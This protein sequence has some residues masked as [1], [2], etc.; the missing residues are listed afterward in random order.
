MAKSKNIKNNKKILGNTKFDG[1][2]KQAIIMSVI[3]L[4]LFGAFYLLTVV[5]LDKDLLKDD[6][7]TVNTEI[8][9]SEILVGSSFNRPVDEYLVVYYDAT[10]E[11]IGSEIL[12]IVSTYRTS[13]NSLNL[14]NVN[15]GDALNKRFVVTEDSNPSATKASEMKIKNPT[16]I[17]IKEGSIVDYIEGVDSIKNYL[18]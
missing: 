1:Q 11:E 14:Y 7:N 15:L 2:I 3:V 9:Q 18:Q 6:N 16:L 10:D 12:S 4:V 8:Q 5:I 13:E 17:K